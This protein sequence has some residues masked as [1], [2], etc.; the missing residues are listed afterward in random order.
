MRLKRRG[1]GAGA[2]RA[3]AASP[4]AA[5]AIAPSD[6][7]GAAAPRVSRRHPP[8]ATI[9]HARTTGS[10]ALRFTSRLAGR[11]DLDLGRLLL[12]LGRLLRR[13]AAGA[14]QLHVE[15]E[16]LGAAARARPVRA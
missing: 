10:A 8:A 13:L 14:L 1:G 2:G 16:R 12:A 3:L 11:Q 7:G 5:V 4:I 6:P 9:A 15:L